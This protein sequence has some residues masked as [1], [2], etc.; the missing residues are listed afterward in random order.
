M[1]S[2]NVIKLDTTCSAIGDG[3]LTGGIN[4]NISGITSTNCTNPYYYSYQWPYS[5]II[6][7]NPLPIADITL[8]K[9]ENGWLLSKGGKDYVITE[10]KEILKY[11]E[12]KK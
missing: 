3:I 5:N 7:T 1:N 10:P 11:L 9:V 4:G 2:S 8:R 12:N 6:Y